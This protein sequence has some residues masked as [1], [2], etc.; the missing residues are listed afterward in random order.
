MS[1]LDAH[2]VEVEEGGHKIGRYTYSR[3]RGLRSKFL[4]P[5][6]AGQEPPCWSRTVGGLFGFGLA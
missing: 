3:V 4:I 1:T 6:I 2:E 5:P